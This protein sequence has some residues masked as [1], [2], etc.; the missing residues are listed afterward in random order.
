M[1]GNAPEVNVELLAAVKQSPEYQAIQE[2]LVDL[3][4]S[5][6]WQEEGLQFVVFQFRQGDETTIDTTES[7]VAVFT[8]NPEFS[9][10]VAAVIVTPRR[11][12]EPDEITN[13]R[14]HVRGATIAV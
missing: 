4:P 10:L 5:D 2:R 7:P 8:M 14:E 1:H 11:N 3:A 13:L 9:A 6:A 12:G